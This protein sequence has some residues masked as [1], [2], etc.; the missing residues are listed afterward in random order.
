VSLHRAVLPSGVDLHWI[1]QGAGDVVVLL[2]GGMGDCHSWSKQLPALASGFRA[3]AYSRRYSHP[4][5]NAVTVPEPPWEDVHDLGQLVDLLRLDRFHLVGTSYGALVALLY[6]LAHPERAAS[7]VLCEPPL[8]RLGARTPEGARMCAEFMASAWE[9]AAAAFRQ[10]DERAAI[11]MLI[12]A[13]WGQPGFSMR[14]PRNVEKA[15]RN[16]RAMRVLTGAKDP[17]PAIAGEAIGALRMPVLLA[18]GERTSPLHRHLVNEVARALP[19]AEL[20]VVGGAGHAA[21]A[22]N[23]QGF[24]SA[25]LR[26]LDKVGRRHR[27]PQGTG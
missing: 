15:L 24:N 1:E 3:I 9:P 14:A 25:L 23:S 8:H 22:E 12:D 16:A 11:A 21:P 19:A 18:C 10:E 5:A 26:F 4:N 6:A 13:M 20:V 7:L 17:F 2:H 27:C